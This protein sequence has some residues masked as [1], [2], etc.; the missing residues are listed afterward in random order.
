MRAAFPSCPLVLAAHGPSATLLQQAGVVDLG[1]AFDDP[2]LAWIFQEGESPQT[3]YGR[4]IAWMTSPPAGLTERLRRED[5]AAVAIFPTQPAPESDV[6]AASFLLGT[7]AALG[8]ER[9]LDATSLQIDSRPM[10]EILVHPGSGS[11]RKNWPPQLFARVL[12]RLHEAGAPLSLVVG[13]ADAV[14]AGAVEMALGQPLPRVEGSLMD[15][16]SRLAAARAY[17]G[18]DSG[19]SHLAGLCGA[20][21]FVLFGPTDPR[22]WA[23]LGPRVSTLPFDISPDEV[24][25]RL[26]AERA[27]EAPERG[28]SSS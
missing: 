6:H 20:P 28:Q 7:L 25:A 22:V 19:V 18:N 27:A 21:S 5:G 8:I 15:L 14:A 10:G 13:E 11:T 2:S 23:P 26:L 12:E 16:A 9:A 24:V 1:L 4:V 3:P 17:L